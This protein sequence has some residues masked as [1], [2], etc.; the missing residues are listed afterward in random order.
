MR[1]SDTSHLNKFRAAAHRAMALAAL[2][3]NSSLSVRLLRYNEAM[4]RA[5]ALESQG[6]SHV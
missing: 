2:Q 5:R 1:Y 6:G 3:Q 4:A